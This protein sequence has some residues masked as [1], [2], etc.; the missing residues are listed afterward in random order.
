MLTL[1]LNTWLLS[2]QN[3]SHFCHDWQRVSNSSSHLIVTKRASIL[4]LINIT[5]R[6][7]MSVLSSEASREGE[8]DSIKPTRR[9]YYCAI[10][11]TWVF[12]WHNSSLT[13]SRR[14]SMHW[15]WVMISLRVTPLVEEEGPDVDG[16][17]EAEEVTVSVCGRL[18]WS[19]ASLCLMVAASMAHM[20]KKWSNSG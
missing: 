12:T 7:T 18:D 13:V 10:W 20:T 6:V 15:S 2:S 17:E 3:Y 9:A 11:P 1:P 14:A 19:W 4:I 16:V 8:G 5:I